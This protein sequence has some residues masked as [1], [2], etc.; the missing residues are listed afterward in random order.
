M[1]EVRPF[2]EREREIFDL[3]MREI[4]RLI[5][6][7][8]ALET[9]TAEY[10]GDFKEYSVSN[11]VTDLRLALVG[12]L[13]ILQ[14]F[15]EYRDSERAMQ[16][17]TSWSIVH[18][19]SENIESQLLALSNAPIDRIRYAAQSLTGKLSG[20]FSY[21]KSAIQGISAK[22]WSL[23]SK[24]LRLKEWSIKGAVNS[25]ALVNLFSFSGSVELELTFGP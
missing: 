15:S 18:G 3:L 9:Q 10:T 2:T 21:L 19:Q 8:E 20:W 7:I 1:S 24:Y 11:P 5:Q 17:V 6:E 22:L 16:A 12:L 14:E 4:R 23:L 25:P 13:E